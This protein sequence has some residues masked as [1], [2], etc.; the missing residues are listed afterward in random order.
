MGDIMK[1]KGKMIYKSLYFLS[2]LLLNILLCVTGFLSVLNNYVMDTMYQKE[3]NTNPDIK[4]IAID[5]KSLNELGKFSDW[6]RNY[7]TTLVEKLNSDNHIPAVI[8]FD[9]LFTGVEDE[10]KDLEFAEKCGEYDNVV[11]AM[12][13]LFDTEITLNDNGINTTP[14]VTGESVA[15]KQLYENT[16]SGFVNTILDKNDGYVRKCIPQIEY[17]GKF[18]NACLD[19][20]YDKNGNGH[21]FDELPYFD[22]N[23]D[24]EDMLDD[25]DFDI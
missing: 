9:I 16:T 3:S 22:N 17:N 13:L 14:N 18:Y 5:D 15:Y 7:Y 10:T 2:F 11:V 8:A 23:K 20:F 1:N 25:I 6:S 21:T 19:G 24:E 12:N 4:I